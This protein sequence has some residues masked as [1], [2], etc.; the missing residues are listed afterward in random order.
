VCIATGFLFF[1]EK[2]KRQH[3]AK[4][5]AG[6]RIVDALA[7]TTVTGMVIAAISLLIANRLLPVDVPGRGDWEELAFWAAWALALGH[8]LWRTA[9]VRQARIAP[10]WREQCGA[11]AALAVTAV[12]LNWVTTGDHLGKTLMQ[13]YWPVAGLDLCLLSVAALA[14]F[15]ARQL[16]ARA[17]RGDALDD[18]GEAA[19]ATGASALPAGAANV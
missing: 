5:A 8:A 7:V 13:A 4:G 17:A 19:D 18:A 1:V 2:R 12:G 11:I 3:A 15:A 10:A 14:A 9:P 6:S 16:R